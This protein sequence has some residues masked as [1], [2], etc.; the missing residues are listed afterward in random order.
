MFAKLLALVGL[1]VLAGCAEGPRGALRIP[2]DFP[3]PDSALPAA[4]E[5]KD[6]W[7]DPAPP[8]RIFGQVYYVGTCGITALLIAEGDWLIL[9]DG[10]T[11]EAAPMI[12]ANIGRRGFRPVDVRTILTSHEHVDHVGGVAALKRL[13]R[14]RLVARAPARAVLES[15]RADPADPQHGS[16]P[17]FEGATVDRIVRDRETLRNG[18]FKITAHAT[19]GHTPGSTTWTWRSCEGRVCRNFVY[20]DSLSAVAREGYRFSDHPELVAQFRRTFD[21][22]AALPCDVLITPHPSASNLFERL[23]GRAPLADANACRAYA[24]TAR[25]RLDERLAREAAQ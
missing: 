25:R 22:V 16:I 19:P 6:G 10:A 17:G 8:A 9:I 15:G 5:G 23:A 14:G 4:C 1:A 13:T 24:E 12:A 2:Y 7:S 18:R 11:A 3:P 20:A 21:R